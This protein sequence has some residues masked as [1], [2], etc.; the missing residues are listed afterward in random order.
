MCHQIFYISKNIA[1]TR[2]S[3]KLI[4]SADPQSRPVGI[5]VFAHVVSTSV[6]TFQNLAK[7]NKA[8]TKVTTSET[9]GLAVWIIDDTCLVIICFDIL[10]ST[11]RC[12]VKLHCIEP[13][14]LCACNVCRILIFF[15]YIK[16]DF[17]LVMN[18][19]FIL[20]KKF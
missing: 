13:L 9:V 18:P 11:Y 1:N 15:R 6:S 4:H 19:F 20:K 8:K 14:H 10:Q 17:V 2:T 16:I 5:I 3:K 7:Q 12:N